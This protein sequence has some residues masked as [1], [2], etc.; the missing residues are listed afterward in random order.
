MKA[1]SV[2][3]Q[4]GRERRKRSQILDF[5]NISGMVNASATKNK[6]IVLHDDDFYPFSDG[7][8]QR[9]RN[10]AGET[11]IPLLEQIKI[12]FKKCSKRLSY[13]RSFCD[14]EYDEAI[15]LKNKF[16]TNQQ[17]TPYKSDRGVNSAKRVKILTELCASVESGKQLFWRQL[18]INDD[19]PDL[20]YQSGVST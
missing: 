13:K 15:V 2:H 17:P 7:S 8:K 4:I 19:V 1:D 18:P 5:N 10:I 12:A 11:H 20:L 14:P 9:R 16:D 3:G 6:P